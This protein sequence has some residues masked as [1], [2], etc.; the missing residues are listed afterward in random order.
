MMRT[1]QARLRLDED[2]SGRL[3][4][5]ARLYG[6]VERS[7]FAALASGRAKNELKREYIQRFGITARHFN[8]IRIGLEGKVRSI[9][10]RQPDLIK[11]VTQRIGKAGT[12]IAKLRDI[13]GG[14]SEQRSKRAN[15]IHQKMRRLAI[16]EHRK[17]DMLRDQKN[18][19][20]RL[21]FGSKKLFRAQFDLDANGYASREEWLTDWKASRSSEFL[22]I[23]SKDETAGNQSCQ[24][25]V[26]PEG[27][28]RLKL[29]L[30]NAIGRAIELIKMRDKPLPSGMG[31]DSAD[32]HAVPAFARSQ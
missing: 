26:I 9:Q 20:V 7:L 1:W 21:C 28:Y 14:T 8:A 15:K 12:T 11:E 25:Q 13:R 17:S 19:K 30:P 29:R 6:T 10:E 2:A 18:G 3:A 5:Y 32:G 4:A 27:G 24:L 23:G 16:L 31:K 22:L